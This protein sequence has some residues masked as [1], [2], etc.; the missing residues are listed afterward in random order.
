VCRGEADVARAGGHLYVVGGILTV[1]VAV[2]IVLALWLH[3]GAAQEEVREQRRTALAKGPPV[4]TVQVQLTDEGREVVLPAETRG[5]DQTTVYAK[6]AGYVRKLYVERGQQVR[7][8]EIIAELESPETERDV[9]A[10]RSDLLVK[11]VTATRTR[12]L[13]RRKLLAPQDRDDA[14]A[15]ER[16]AL[17]TYERALTTHGYTALRAPFDGVVVARY[18]DPGA[19]LPAA[20]SATESAAALVDLATLDRLR[21]FIYVGQ[22]A[23]AFVHDGDR[24][25][26]WQD[27][28]PE[29]RLE[30]V[31]T[32]TTRALDPRTRTMQV[33]IDLD[34]TSAK[35]LPGTFVRVALHLAVPPSPVVP[36]EA[37]TVRDGNVNVAIVD[38]GRVHFARVE[39]GPTDGKTTRVMRGLRGDE[40]IA[41]NLPVEVDEGGPIQPRPAADAGPR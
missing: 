23:A 31:V 18:V 26:L 41:V 7:R 13:E 5:F 33:E 25:E 10:A 15:A 36:N 40:T 16:I 12:T 14:A 21:V 3:Q 1:F 17:A 11:R 2:A 38:G 9:E 34:N 28:L 39:L 27:E 30:A 32:R 24:A 29:K 19:L 20:T 8:G 4:T 35:I 37:F 22:D 6:L